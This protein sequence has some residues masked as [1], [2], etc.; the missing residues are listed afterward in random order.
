MSDERKFCTECGA[1]NPID[2]RFCTEC[3]HELDPVEESTEE[4]TPVVSDEPT[5]EETVEPT[6]EPITEEPVEETPVEDEPVTEETSATPKEKKEN[7]LNNI[8][9][10]VMAN[11]VALLIGAAVLIVA[12]ALFMFFSGTVAV[13]GTW[14]SSDD[15]FYQSR[16]YETVTISRGGNVEVHSE[17]SDELNGEYTYTFSIEEDEWES[18]DGRTVYAVTDFGEIE[19]VVPNLTYS[20]QRRNLRDLFDEVEPDINEGRNDVTLTWDF[21]EEDDWEDLLGS[22]A[23]SII[24]LVDEDDSE[25]DHGETYVIIEGILGSSELFDR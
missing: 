24:T 17:P 3:G 13:R 23:E 10:F 21:S 9:P 22:S 6:E 20:N 19:L 2:N 5:V 12:V 7:P 1:E 4:V 15:D 16:V 18:E 8:V 11:K 14:E 25:N